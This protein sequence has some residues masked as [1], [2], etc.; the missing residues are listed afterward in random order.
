MA[1]KFNDLPGWDFEIDEV[2]AGVY[3]IVGVD[4]SGHEVSATG[5]DSDEL[6]KQAR[7]DALTI[8]RSLGRVGLW[9]RGCDHD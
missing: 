1:E 4:K 5:F 8:M 7:L 9:C 3:K 2:S 6:I